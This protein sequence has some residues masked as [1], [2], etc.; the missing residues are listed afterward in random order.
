[1][2]SAADEGWR[3]PPAPETATASV[4]FAVKIGMEPDAME[5]AAETDGA[6]EAAGAA[7]EA[8]LAERVIVIMVV[9]VEVQLEDEEVETASSETAD[10]TA[11]DATV[12]AGRT[13]VR[14]L[15]F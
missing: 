9:E 2:D 12:V 5:A 8:E 11:V 3:T 6:D 15:S 14:C 7:L 13:L 1:L 4:G 10:E